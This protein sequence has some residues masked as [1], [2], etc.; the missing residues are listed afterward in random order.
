VMMGPLTPLPGARPVG[1]N[2]VVVVKGGNQ[3][4]DKGNSALDIMMVVF[5]LLA[6]QYS[7]LPIQ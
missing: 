1:Y 2:V 4:A 3:G 6:S 7:M 5:A